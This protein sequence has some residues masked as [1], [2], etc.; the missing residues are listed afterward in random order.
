MEESAFLSSLRKLLTVL[1]SLR[2]LLSFYPI[3][4]SLKEVQSSHHREN[5]CLH[6][7]EGAVF[8]S[9]LREPQSY[10]TERTT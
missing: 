7:I 3:F 5:Y 8:F 9:S 10:I 4:T 6:I 1:T 2:E